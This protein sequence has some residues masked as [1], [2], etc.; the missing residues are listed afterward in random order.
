MADLLVKNGTIVDGTGAKAYA[1]DLRIKD[2]VIVEI[3]Q[4]LDSQGE[5]CSPRF[6]RRAYSCGPSSMVGPI[7]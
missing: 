4:D 5:H 1:A 2:G 6:Y 7:L 3:G